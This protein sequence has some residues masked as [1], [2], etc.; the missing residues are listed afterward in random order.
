MHIR[1]TC[2]HLGYASCPFSKVTNY[3]STDYNMKIVLVLC[4]MAVLIHTLYNNGQEDY[5]TVN[6]IMALLLGMIITLQYSL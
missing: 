2:F 1:N 4:M 5:L 3:I 6:Q